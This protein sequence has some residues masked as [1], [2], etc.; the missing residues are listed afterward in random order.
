M[1]LLRV[2]GELF[3][4]FLS[5]SVC[6]FPFDSEKLSPD[7]Y[8]FLVHSIPRLPVFCL[9]VSP[10]DSRTLALFCTSLFY[11]YST[12]FWCTQFFLCSFVF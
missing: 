11:F 2:A 6:L 4:T 1:V 7:F 5:C 8:I 9:F 3:L 12:S 10:A